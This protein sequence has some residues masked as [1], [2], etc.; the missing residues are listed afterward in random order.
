MLFKLDIITNIYLNKILE[1][2]YED[3]LINVFLID[4]FEN[5]VSDLGDIYISEKN[6]SIEAIM[7]MK[8]DG[9]SHFTSFYSKSNSGLNDI[10][11]ALKNIDKKKILLA[12][13]TTDVEYILSNLNL[14]KS[15]SNDIYYV[16]DSNM[17]TNKDYLNKL[18]P[19]EAFNVNKITFSNITPSILKDIKSF[20]IDFFNATSKEDILALSNDLLINKY[21]KNGLYLFSNSTSNIGMLRFA[22]ASK[23]YIDITGLYIKQDFRGKNLSTIFMNLIIKEILN[24][25]KIPILQTNYKN[26]VAI[27][28]YEN[29]GFIKFCNY[30]FEFVS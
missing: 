2:L 22:G 3:E 13:K 18:N 14:N 20:N 10:S 9:N 6:N 4:S 29:L 21:I 8:F 7:H 11:K 19:L 25:G 15:V 1:L 12:G 23:K 24:L 28:L 16:L 26:E 5:K 17:H 30:S 27:H